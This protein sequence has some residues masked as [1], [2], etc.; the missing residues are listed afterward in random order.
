[1]L[2]KLADSDDRVTVFES[3][4]H[5]AHDGNMQL[6]SVGQADADGTL[7][8]LTIGYTFTSDNTL[9]R[10]FPTTVSPPDL[11]MS[12]CALSLTLDEQVYSQVRQTVIDE[13]GG[14]AGSLIAE[15]KS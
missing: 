11:S 5:T 3:E 9:K 4:S 12:N 14:R 1:M 2:N 13:L 8:V 6:L 15:L 7:A 10:T